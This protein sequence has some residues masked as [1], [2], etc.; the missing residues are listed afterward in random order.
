MKEIGIINYNCGNITSLTNSI[1]FLKYDFKLINDKNEL[2]KFKKIILPGVGA[3]DTAIDSLNDKDLFLSLKDWIDDHSNKL[4][5]ICLGMQVL[6]IESEESKKN[7]KGLS[8]INANVEN[9]SNKLELTHKVPHVGWNSI[10]LKENEV[11]KSEFNNRDFY[12]LHS[13]AAYINDKKSNLAETSYQN[14]TFNSMIT[15]GINVYGA[16]FHP[17]K[18][19]FQGLNLIKNFIDNA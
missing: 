11:F 6:C 12:F 9:L 5:G 3:F 17:E 16:Q 15:N 7:K 13:Y 18:S 1:K 19:H 14:V 10:K 2:F 8:V 4:L